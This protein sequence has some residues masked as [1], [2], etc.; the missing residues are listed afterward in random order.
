M[1][2]DVGLI[3]GI[4]QVS[5]GLRDRFGEERVRDGMTSPEPLG[6]PAFWA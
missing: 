3:G 2:E 6:R 5:K 4:F 1:G